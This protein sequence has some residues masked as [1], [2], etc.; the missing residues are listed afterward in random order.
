[1]E[2]HRILIATDSFSSIGKIGNCW[3]D[4][5]TIMAIR[6]YLFILKDRDI[7]AHIRWARAHTGIPGNERADTLAKAGAEIN[8]SDPK[9]NGY[10]N[11]IPI[12]F[13][14]GRL[15][16]LLWRNYAFYALNNSKPFN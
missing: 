8:L 5:P 3:A 6:R 11:Y 10:F 15:E 7:A 12:S 1:M 16:S 2:I 9:N 4:N 13:L 14:K